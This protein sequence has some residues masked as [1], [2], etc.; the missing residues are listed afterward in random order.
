MAEE[1]QF[2][3]AVPTKQRDL[4]TL[5]EALKKFSR[6]TPPTHNSWVTGKTGEK[7]TQKA[8]KEWTTDKT[9]TAT[10]AV[11]EDD[12]KP[13]TLVNWWDSIRTSS[14]D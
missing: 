13:G 6:W 12:R 9:T 7:R 8:E 4:P 1:Q 14:K 5:E 10:T 11:Q 2:L 3:T